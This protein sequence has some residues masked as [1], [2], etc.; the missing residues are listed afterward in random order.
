MFGNREKGVDM[1]SKNRS[2]HW[3][4]AVAGVLIAAACVTVSGCAGRPCLTSGKPFT[5]VV[6]PDTQNYA[7]HYPTTFIEQLTWI[8]EEKKARN[9]VCVIHEGDITNE[10]SDKEW[11]VADKAMSLIDGVVPYCM[12][13]GNHDYPGGPATRNSSQFNKH[14]GSQRFE[15]EPWYGGHFGEGNENA[16]YLVRAEGI[17]FLVLCLEFGPR[18]KVLEWANRVV[19][20]HKHYRTIVVT[21]CYTYSDDTRV[22]KGD[23]WN[24]RAVY[25]CDNDGDDMWDKF[26]KK[27]S[28]I[29]LV[30]SGHILNDGLGRLTSVGDKE[31]KIHQ[32]LANYQMKP[33]GG[34]GWLRIMEFIPKEKKIVVRTYSPTLRRY[35]E[36]AD[37][38]FEL[39]YK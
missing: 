27:H 14:F 12:V 17:D 33:N 21:H 20:E 38:H 18:D 4:G 5:I 36:D 22:G 24:P 39:E 19:S 2:F 32:I 25:G 7:S 30:L 1:K 16:F 34:D 23:E 26:V 9:I 28:N 10:S 15:K 3:S 11:E 31:N 35:A 29:F 13:M 6:L 37:N 8:K